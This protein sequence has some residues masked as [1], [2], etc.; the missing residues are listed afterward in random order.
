MHYIFLFA[1]QVFPPF[2]DVVALADLLFLTE[3]VAE[4]VGTEAAHATP[5]LFAFYLVFFE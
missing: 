5:A 3:T 1:Y 2:V 4:E